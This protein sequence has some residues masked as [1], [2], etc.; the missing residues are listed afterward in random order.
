MAAGSC[1]NGARWIPGILAIALIASGCTVTDEFV[2]PV[3][4]TRLVLAAPGLAAQSVSSPERPQ[5]AGWSVSQACLDL[6]GTTVDLVNLTEGCSPGPVGDDACTFTDTVNISPYS[7]KRCAGGVVIGATP[8]EVVEINLTLTFTMDVRRA[9]PVELP[10]GGDYDNDGKYNEDDN[11]PMVGNQDQ[12][13][14]NSNGVGDH[15]EVADGQG[16]Y[17][18]DTDG[19]G[20]PDA[21]DNCVWHPNPGQENTTGVEGGSVNDGIGDACSPG[22]SAVVEDQ[23]HATEISVAKGPVGLAQERSRPSF[24]TV[25]F[26]Y[27]DEA[28]VCDDWSGACVLDT[29]AIRLCVTDS[30][31]S[32][33]AGCP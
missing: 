12:T 23:N 13:D 11:C 20:V 6:G 33:G 28:L 18:L 1:V 7:T 32:A 8:G 21:Y 30:L 29:S 5:V 22:Q 9:V 25:D 27:L 3:G 19:D 17:L 2:Q 14:D 4:T 15:C 10:A 26:A 31:A 24:I 16:G